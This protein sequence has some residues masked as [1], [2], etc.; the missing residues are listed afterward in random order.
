MKP[1]NFTNPPD[2]LTKRGSCTRDASCET[3][4]Y[5]KPGCPRIAE[6]LAKMKER[7]K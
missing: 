7:G 5:H 1:L 6:M 4:S 2:E 3:T